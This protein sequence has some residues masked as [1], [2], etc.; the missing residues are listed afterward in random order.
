MSER[1]ASV[2]LVVDVGN[3][4]TVLGVFHGEELR[5]H[6]RVASEGH[7]TPD[8]LGV[9][10]RSLFELKGI[11]VGDIGG[12]AISSVVPAL[13]P[14]FEEVAVEYFHRQPLVVGPGI[15][16]GMPIQY[17]DP[18]EVGA[19]RIVNAVAG[20]AKYQTAL[21]IV[22]FGTATT[23]DYVSPEGAYMGGMIAPGLAIGMEALFTRTSKLPKVTLARPPRVL[24]RNTVH[25]MQS[26]ILFGY[27][28]LVDGLIDRLVAEVGGSPMVLATGGLGPLVAAETRRIH[29]VEEFLTLEGLRILYDRNT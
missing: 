25:S 27:A 7:R 28:A 23:F 21:V 24:G 15:R 3:T 9:L 29:R 10:L 6:W 20:Y 2:L 22:D 12:I 11:G 16:T 14:T 8:E 17:E 19:D 18:R 4:H 1:D 26:G 5:G 13:T